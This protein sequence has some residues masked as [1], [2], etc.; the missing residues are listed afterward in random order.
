[1]QHILISVVDDDLVID[2]EDANLWRD[3]QGI[4]WEILEPLTWDNTTHENTAVFFTNGDWSTDGGTTPTPIGTLPTGSDRR[5][6]IAQGPG[7]NAGPG[8]PTYEYDLALTDGNGNP[9][10]LREVAGTAKVTPNSNFGHSSVV[11][12]D[13]S[14]QPHP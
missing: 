8:T 2:P 11:D 1:M 14:N 7:S 3:D 5:V 4:M 6:Y 9:F 10:R 13:I 12:P